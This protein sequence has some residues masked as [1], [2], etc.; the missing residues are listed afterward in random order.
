MIENL[1]REDFSQVFEIM[2]ESFPSDEYRTYKEQEALL[3]HSAYSI[4]VIYNKEK[5]IKAFI[6]SWEFP[7][8]VYIEHL[9]VNSHYRNE[10]LGAYILNEQVKLLDKMVCLEVE[11]PNTEIATR[12]IGFYERNNFHLNEYSYTQPAMSEGKNEIPLFIMTSDCEV[13]EDRFMEIK[14]T[15]YAEVYKV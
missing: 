8:F 1:K 12:R 7:T 10:G 15:L 5:E 13:D 2:E 9:A 11:L 6:A 14:N 3:D 4:Y